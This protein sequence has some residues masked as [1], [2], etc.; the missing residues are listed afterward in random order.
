MLLYKYV[1]SDRIDVLE[2]SQI[3]FTQPAALNDPFEVLPSFEEFKDAL[4]EGTV[5]KQLLEA[6]LTKFDPVSTDIPESCKEMLKNLKTNDPT[7]YRTYLYNLLNIVMK[8]ELDNRCAK[9]HLDFMNRHFAILSV[10]ARRDHPLMWSHYADSHRGFVIGFD[11]DDPLFKAGGRIASVGV[12]EVTYSKNRFSVPAAG[13]DGLSREDQKKACIAFLFI[14]SDD[15]AYE[16]ELRCLA[17]PEFA[18]V[19]IPIQHGMPIYLYKFTPA[20]VKEIIL[21]KNMQP[22]VKDALLLLLKEKY[23]H[24]QIF[25][26]SLHASRFELCIDPYDY[27]LTSIESRRRDEF[28][29]SQAAIGVTPRNGKNCT[30]SRETEHE[31]GLIGSIWDSRFGVHYG[32]KL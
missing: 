9:Q 13:L 28:L 24:V 29:S 5:W 16:E 25:R 4:V 17:H 27:Q 6:R 23:P 7:T 2:H 26:E 20:S 18:E 11:N 3:R 22:G 32:Q 14:K 19:T 31:S 1:C 21:G 15:W 12:R 8:V 10:S 30:L